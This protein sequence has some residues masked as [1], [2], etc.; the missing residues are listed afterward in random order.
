[1]HDDAFTFAK[2]LSLAPVDKSLKLC[3]GMDVVDRVVFD[4]IHP[5]VNG[6]KNT[7]TLNL[8]EGGYPYFIGP[9]AIFGGRPE[10]MVPA[11]VRRT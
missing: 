1:M 2:G 4:H 7:F 3:N 10:S 9:V 8:E 6:G 5:W 11:E